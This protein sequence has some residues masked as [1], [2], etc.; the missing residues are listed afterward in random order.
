MYGLRVCLMSNFV[1]GEDRSKLCVSQSLFCMRS[2]DL[3]NSMTDSEVSN[4]NISEVVS[5]NTLDLLHLLPGFTPFNSLDSL[6]LPGNP[7]ERC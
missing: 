3:S 7:R 2:L 1:L 6:H 4:E 5:P